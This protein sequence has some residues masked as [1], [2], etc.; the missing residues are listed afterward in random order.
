MATMTRLVA[1]HRDQH[2]DHAG[3]A[4]AKPIRRRSRA[5]PS[6]PPPVM[7][8]PS[9]WGVTVG[10]VERA[11]QPAAEDDLDP[12]G[13]ADQ[14]VEVGRDQQ[15]RQ[16]VAAGRLDVLPDRG[17]GADVDAAGRVRGDQQRPGRRSSRGRRSASAGCRRTAPGRA[18]RCRACARRTRATMRS[19]SRAGTAAV[20]PRPAGARG[21]GLV[22][23]D[24]VLPERARRAA[25][26]AGGGP[27]G[28][29][30]RRP[31]GGARVSQRGDVLV[32]E[33]GSCRDVALAHAHHGLDQLGLAVA[34]DAGDAEH[35][36]PVDLEA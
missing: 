2:R 23:E 6:S 11:D 8:A 12:V 31:R 15:H 13:E 19:V 28:C 16:A 18:C 34:L 1:T 7:A 14:L 30:R 35:L 4:A 24:A 22:A 9:S 36:A 25:G 21:P 20:D 33:H 5:H 32:A 17:L 3:R 27:R 10:R 26:R 29:R